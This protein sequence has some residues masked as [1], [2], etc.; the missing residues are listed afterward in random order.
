M[1]NYN[2]HF[3]ICQFSTKNWSIIG[4]ISTLAVRYAVY[5]RLN[6]QSHLLN[7][8]MQLFL[9]TVFFR[10]RSIRLYVRPSIRCPFFALSNQTTVHPYNQHKWSKFSFHCSFFF[11][12]FFDS[13]GLSVLLLDKSLKS[14][15]QHKSKSW[16]NYSHFNLFPMERW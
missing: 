12:S 2:S 8:A 7:V 5:M 10:L 15:K 9:F 11:L 16:C 14:F 1:F 4:N 3:Y 6:E 13:V